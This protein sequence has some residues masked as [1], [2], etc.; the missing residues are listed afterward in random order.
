MNKLKIFSDLKFQIKSKIHLTLNY[1][2]NNM[3]SQMELVISELYLEN[4]I[5]LLI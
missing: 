4:I 1:Y 2:T 3:I 5:S